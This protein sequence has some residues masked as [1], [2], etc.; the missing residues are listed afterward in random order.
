VRRERWGARTLDLDILTFDRAHHRSS[1]VVVPHPEL[2]HRAF[3][4][5]PLVH[6][7][8]DARAPDDTLYLDVLRALPSDVSMQ[9]TD[10]TESFVRET[11]DHTADEGF[12]VYARD[13]ADLFAAAAEALGA[14]IVDGATV[15]PIEVVPVVAG[16]DPDDDH[17]ARMVAWASEVLH[18]LDGGCFALRRAVVFDDGRHEIRG[19]LYGEALDE[20]RHAVRCAVKAI[21]WH[22]LDVAPQRDGTWRAQVVVD[23]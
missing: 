20:H 17:D 8:P 7:R 16:V 19:C 23:L 2:A 13:R 11:V 10:F 6:L 21:T 9:V 4:L 3:A 5:A 15:A 14:I 22:A 12:V 1:T 18:H